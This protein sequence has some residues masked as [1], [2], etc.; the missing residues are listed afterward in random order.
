MAVKIRLQRK[1]RK[2]APFYYVVV[3]DSRSPR[4]GRFIERIGSYN[5]VPKLPVVDIDIDKAID[6]LDKGAQPTKTVKN[7]LSREGILYKK[8]LLR[9]V[10]LGVLT[11]EQA[12]EKFEAYIKEK[13][14]KH[15]Q[16]QDKLM[17]EKNQELKKIKDRESKISEERAREIAK[18]RKEEIEANMPEEEKAEE[19]TPEE[20]Q[21]VETPK[22][23]PKAE[24]AKPEEPKEEKEEPKKEE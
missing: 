10:K 9:G 2:K 18:K 8:H 20:T 16:V 13:A 14:E 17:D 22:E 7:L 4:D 5:P 19:E 11:Q 1:G 3:A 12:D 24:E 15:E 23:E 21:E 6:W